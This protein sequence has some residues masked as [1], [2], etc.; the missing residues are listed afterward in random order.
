TLSKIAC[1]RL[2]KELV[3]WQANPPTGFNYK[4]SDNL[5]R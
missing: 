3:E 1:N 5:Q 2:Q 4:V